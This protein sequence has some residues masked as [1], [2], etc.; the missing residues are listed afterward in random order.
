[1]T[2][3]PAGVRRS[4]ILRSFLVQGSWNFETLIGTGF[5]FVLY[6]VLRHIYRDDPD[7]LRAA[8]FRH[9]EMF[10]SHPYLATLAVGAVAR[11]EAEGTDPEVVTRFKNALRGAM[12][13]M[14]DQLVWLSWRPAVALLAIALLLLD[15]PWWLAVGVY[16]VCYNALHLWLRVW[17]LRLGWQEGLGVARLLREAPLGVWGR[18]AVNSGLVLAG[19]CTALAVGRAGTEL[20][21]VGIAVAAAV[22]GAAL[23]LRIRRPAYVGLLLVWAAGILMGLTL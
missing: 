1:V 19:L 22:A 6:P 21:E 16:L 3:L 11:L 13:A 9:S 14:G 7:A 18:R 8:V 20:T 15:L 23:G 12:G 17:G 5:A 4:V 10:N 2:T